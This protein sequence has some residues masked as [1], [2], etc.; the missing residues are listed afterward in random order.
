MSASEA[1]AGP[2]AAA[3]QT[4]AGR[5]CRGAGPAKP[6][7]A[8]RRGC[9]GSGSP[10]ICRCSKCP[11]PALVAGAAS[12][13]RTAPGVSGCAGCAARRGSPEV[14]GSCGASGRSPALPGAWP[15]APPHG[16]RSS[17]EKPRPAHANANAGGC[18]AASSV[19][20]HSGFQSPDAGASRS[21]AR[22]S[23]KLD[24]SDGAAASWP[25]C[26]SPSSAP[27]GHEAAAAGFASD[28]TKD[29][30]GAAA[31][32]FGQRAARQRGKRGIEASGVRVASYTSGGRA[33]RV[34]P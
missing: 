10:R 13:R 22:T 7:D 16:P 14:P 24:R 28:A 18:E 15:E 25:S 30:A 23:P 5:V 12:T 34:A 26:P 17:A 9:A 11:E 6:P 29:T 33:R 32:A 4:E 20:S 8:T 31:A 19:S 2:T 27:P 3:S 1:A 21:F